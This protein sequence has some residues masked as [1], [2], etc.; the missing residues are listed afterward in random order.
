[1]ALKVINGP[2]V[3]DLPADPASLFLARCLLERLTQRLEFAREAIDRMVLA[4]DEAC[5]NVIRH[6]YGNRPGERIVLTFLVGSDRLEIQIRDFGSQADPAGFK[7]RDLSDIRPGGLGIHFIR[8]A[9]DE[10]RYELPES[11]GTLLRMVKFY[12]GRSD[13]SGEA[14]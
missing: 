11:G 10:V 2:V 8:S 13:V 5:S 9:M 12:P 3:L 14:R 4:V 1:M 6:A 7:S